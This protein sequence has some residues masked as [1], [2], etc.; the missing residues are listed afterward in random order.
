MRTRLIAATV[1]LGCV[2]GTAGSFGVVSTFVSA[3]SA[4]AATMGPGVIWDGDGESHLSAYIQPD[5]SKTICLQ[6]NASIP[7]ST[8]PGPS[9]N[10]DWNSLSPNVIAGI[11]GVLAENQGVEDGYTWAAIQAAGW[12]VADHDNYQANGGDAYYLARAN[13]GQAAV[14]A[15]KD[16]FV[17]QM[18]AGQAASGGTVDFASSLSYT[19]DPATLTGTV[20]YDADRAVAPVVHLTNAT[21]QDTGTADRVMSAGETLPINVIPNADATFQVSATSDEVTEQ[22]PEGY[23]GN[24]TTWA[25]GAPGEQWTGGPGQKV[26]TTYRTV[27]ATSAS[28]PIPNLFS[29]IASTE[30]STQRVDAGQQATDK[31]HVGVAEG[32][33]EWRK[34][35]DGSY[36]PVTYW[37]K[38]FGAYD[39]MPATT[40]DIPAGAPVAGETS[41]V[42]NGPGDYT[43]SLPVPAAGFYTFVTGVDASAQ[44]SRVQTM[45]P[46]DYSWHDS[47]APVPE[48]FVS[49]F[50]VN[51]SSLVKDNEIPVSADSIDTLTVKDTGAW[52]KKDGKLVAVTFKGT[53]FWVAGTG[54]VPATKPDTATVLT[55]STIVATG[56]G[57]YTSDAATAP[58]GSAGRIVW[59]WSTADTL[60]NNSWADIWNSAGEVVEVTTPDVHTNATP[61]VPLTEGAK[62]EAIVDGEV[63]AGATVTFEAY[64]QSGDKATCT[65]DNR[66]YDG[67]NEPVAV[68]AGDNDKKSYWSKEIRFTTVGTY[69]WVETLRT[70]TGAV[71]HRGECGA[72]GETTKVTIPGVTTQAQTDVALTDGATDVAI[73]TGDTPK[74]ASLIWKAYQAK[75]AADGTVSDKAVCDASTLV[76]DTTKN[77]VAVDKAGSYTS[78]VV[79][80]TYAGKLYWI[81]SLLSYD[82]KVLV[83]GKCGLPN[84]T[85]VV[86]PTPNVHTNATPAGNIGDAVKD[87]A[88]V[89]GMVPEGATITF[90]AYKQTGDAASCTTDNRVYD[91]T[92]SPVATTPGQNDNVSYWSSETHFTEAG[93]YYWVETLSTKDGAV[94]HRGECGAPGETTVVSKESVLP[95]G[96]ADTGDNPA[97]WIGGGIAALVLGLG[98]VMVARKRRATAVVTG[99]TTQE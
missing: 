92:G 2:V 25:P 45:L 21:F 31:I 26:S 78:P 79:V 85:T 75:P 49:P 72:P 53:A 68:T 10:G 13:S 32:S 71:I 9:L 96:L 37:V 8:T 11:N 14:Q 1:A 52:L 42:A 65:V 17:A 70:K 60:Y 51:A 5:G 74:G 81:E 99:D 35:G 98:A 63:P 89:D 62:D 56:P 46:K 93:T 47:F 4:Q 90:E 7:W 82:G 38:M 84:E 24:I 69:Y 77:P 50:D 20:R 55:T 36:A 6:V 61:S 43:V 41:F 91:G 94:I 54:D 64:K 27:A 29:P 67:T 22:G 76:A 80:A 66:V 19:I 18:L 86:H 97:P 73:V 39:E 28:D 83:S 23:A 58:V 88:I 48:T 44:T 59:V 87:E 12:D 57:T 16:Q 34:L 40:A 95:L 33:S 30:V 3:S 15:L